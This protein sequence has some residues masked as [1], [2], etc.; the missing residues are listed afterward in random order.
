ML[1]HLSSGDAGVALVLVRREP[2]YYN[3]TGR[4][5]RQESAYTCGESSV[6]WLSEVMLLMIVVV[7]KFAML[8]WTLWLSKGICV[9][10]VW[11][12]VY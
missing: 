8:W 5:L 1:S 2:K 9:D 12:S 7:A 11:C 3:H 4:G 10:N 6:V